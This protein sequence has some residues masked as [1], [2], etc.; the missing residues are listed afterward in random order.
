MDRFTFVVLTGSQDEPEIIEYNHIKIPQQNSRAEQLYW[1]KKE[2]HGILD[3]HSV[4][5]GCFKATEPISKTKDLHRAEVEGVLQIAGISHP[6]KTIIESRIKSQ[7]N[8]NTN[9]RKAKYLDE[10]L[11]GDL[12]KLKGANYNEACLAALSGLPK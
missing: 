1:F 9:A 8:K 2:V 7:L 3:K 10:L 11:E 4:V 12:N 6:Q 5:S